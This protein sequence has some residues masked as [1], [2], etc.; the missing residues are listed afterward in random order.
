MVLMKTKKAQHGWSFDERL[1][2]TPGVTTPSIKDYSSFNL[3]SV[4]D[5]DYWRKN[6]WSYT[7]KADLKQE[8]F[9]AIVKEALKLVDPET[10]SYNKE[11]ALASALELAIWS[12]DDSKYQ[13]KIH[14]N[15]FEAMYEEM[16]KSKIKKTAGKC[17]KREFEKVGELL[18]L[19]QR[20]SH[21]DSLEEEKMTR[22]Q[23]GEF[24]KRLDKV[25]DQIKST[26]PD[27]A[28][29]IWRVADWLE[30][31]KDEARYMKR[32]DFSGAYERD[33]D[34]KFMDTYD[35][36]PRQPARHSEVARR[37]EGPVKDLNTAPKTKNPHV[38]KAVEDYHWAS[39]LKQASS[40]LD[41]LAEWVEKQGDEKVALEIDK[42]SD[43]IDSELWEVVKHYK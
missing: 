41:N 33:K 19:A 23:A 16:K 7:D 20:L 22:K 34:E 38:D 26:H 32:Y 30:G 21:V 14:P 4:Y 43:N 18:C 13:S 2:K 24:A 27:L 1:K 3:P 8:D 17:P 29:R 5:L 36:I 39:A 42:I 35:D 11:A 10:F 6:P 15:V 31:D 40:Y 12:M 25:A 28:K 9:D 37:H